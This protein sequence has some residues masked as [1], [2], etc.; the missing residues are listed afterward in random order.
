MK[1]R[2]KGIF[3]I[4]ATPFD[5]QSKVDFDSLKKLVEF[6]IKAGVHG[7]T[8]LGILGEVMRLSERER[9]DITEIVVE[10]VNGRVPVVSGTGATGTELA[11]MYS[12]EAE[13]L[14]VDAIMLAPPRLMKPNDEALIKYYHDIADKVGIPIVVQDEPVTYGVSFA[15][16]LIARLSEIEGIEYVKLEDAPTPPKITMIRDLVGDDLG[17]FGGLGGMYAFEELSRGACGVMTGF[18]YP[19]ILVN[20]Y[21]YLSRGDRDDARALFYKALPLI[22]YEAQ[23]LIGLA[24]RKETLK[25]RGAIAT[26]LL[27]EPGAKLDAEGIKELDELL[28]QVNVL[29]LS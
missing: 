22:R 18:A 7:I 25:R 15:P 8:L 21:E 1:Q 28:S 4:L 10:Q 6:E 12:K 13:N 26:A 27:R 19:E 3:A 20:I 24:I 29:N 9:R 16:A 14:G 2:L 23:Q 11:I 17:I 5:V